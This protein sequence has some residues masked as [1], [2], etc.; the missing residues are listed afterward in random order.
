MS[1]LTSL[2]LPVNVAVFAMA[3]NYAGDFRYSTR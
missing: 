1:D 2:S 3:A